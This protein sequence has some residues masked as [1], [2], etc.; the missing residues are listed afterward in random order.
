MAKRGRPGQS[1]RIFDRMGVVV[2]E[3]T[4]SECAMQMDRNTAYIY[5][6]IRGECNYPEHWAVPIG[7]EEEL[8]RK[9][10]D[11]T[12]PLREKFGIPRYRPKE[13]ER[14]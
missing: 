4:A 8:I 5:R 2:A 10:D 3:G 7:T 6:L 1:Y 9:W 14:R 13:E 11:L 12:A